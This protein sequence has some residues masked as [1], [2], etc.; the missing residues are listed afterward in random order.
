MQGH[1]WLLCK[2][3]K[4]SAKLNDIIA[5]GNKQIKQYRDDVMKK[6]PK[7]FLTTLLVAM[8]EPEVPLAETSGWKI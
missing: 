1:N 8:Q 2:N 6:N 5:T 4:D 3:E 7:S